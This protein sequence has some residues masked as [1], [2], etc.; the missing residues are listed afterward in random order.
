MKRSN[1]RTV[2]PLAAGAIDHRTAQSQYTAGA[3]G[4]RK[5]P[6]YLSEPEV[7]S[8]SQTETFVALEILLDSW[9]WAGVPFY[10]R[11]GKALPERIAEIT[12][13][14]PA[15]AAGSFRSRVRQHPSRM[16]PRGA[17]HAV[18]AGS[19]RCNHPPAVTLMGGVH[20]AC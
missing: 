15:T 19:A 5:I 10:V 2:R 1:L 18:F 8:D 3:I 16:R 13:R 12:I 6:H 7:A 20:I 4:D 14:F 11:T 17:Q 9:R